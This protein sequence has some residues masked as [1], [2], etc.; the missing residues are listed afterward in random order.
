MI[1]SSE[2]KPIDKAQNTVMVLEQSLNT[3]SLDNVEIQM[4]EGEIQIF[5]YCKVESQKPR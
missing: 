2:T 3:V 1:F 4:I 5:L